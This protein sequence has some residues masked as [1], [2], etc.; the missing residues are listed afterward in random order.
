MKDNYR[1]ITNTQYI[2]YRLY[3]LAIFLTIVA[4]ISAFLLHYLNTQTSW[5]L[6]LDNEAIHYKEAMIV[7]TVMLGLMFIDI[8]IA[9]I[10]SF[11]ALIFPI[12]RRKRWGVKNRRVYLIPSTD[13]DINVAA[14][15][16]NEK[17]IIAVGNID[18]NYTF[19][20]NDIEFQEGKTIQLLRL[21]DDEM[22]CNTYTEIMEKRKQAEDKKRSFSNDKIQ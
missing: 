10:F 9:Y 21:T 13:T 2:F 14:V 3:N 20:I 6:K 8:V 11:D 5:L 12:K 19:D 22:N 1:E 18:K 15:D 16:I 17:E 7:I 4:A